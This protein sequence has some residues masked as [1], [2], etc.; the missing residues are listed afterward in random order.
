MNARTRQAAIPYEK[1][2]SAKA[3][4][5]NSGYSSGTKSKMN[6][7]FEAIGTEEVF[8]NARVKEILQGPVR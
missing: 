5:M 8:G 4:L 7:L 3:E 6:A 1:I 2:N